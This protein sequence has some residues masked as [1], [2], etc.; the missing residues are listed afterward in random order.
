[1]PFFVD[2]SDA[3]PACYRYINLRKYPIGPY[4]SQPLSDLQIF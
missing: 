2:E 3:L 4:N 1:M